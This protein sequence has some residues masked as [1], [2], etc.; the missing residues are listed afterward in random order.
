M[1]LSWTHFCLLYSTPGVSRQWWTEGKDLI[2]YLL[3]TLHLMKPKANSFF[4][5]FAHGWNVKWPLG[6]FPCRSRFH[7]IYTNT[8]HYSCPDTGFCI[9]LCW[10]PGDSCQLLSSSCF[11]TRTGITWYNMAYGVS[12]T[13]LSFVSSIKLLRMHFVAGVHSSNLYFPRFSVRE[14]VLKVKLA[15]V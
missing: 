15:K 13:P 8:W 2:P 3:K 9:A 7:P 6:H 14:T 5:S 12:A 1:A 4:L 11:G 10:I